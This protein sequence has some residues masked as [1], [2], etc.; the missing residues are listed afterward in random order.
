[1]KTS[2]AK[3]NR[4]KVNCNNSGCAMERSDDGDQNG[5]FTSSSE[6]G[7]SVKIRQSNS[8]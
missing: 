2:P 4:A 8:D 7:S 5:V 6:S 3:R 1:M